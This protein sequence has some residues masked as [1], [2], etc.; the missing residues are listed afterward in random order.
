MIR[1][2]VLFGWSDDATDAQKKRAADE[3]MRLP[4]LVPS[5]RAFG[6][7]PDVG[8]NQG[9]F[10]FA[11]TADFDDVAGYVAYRDNPEHRAMVE[12]HILPIAARRATVQFEF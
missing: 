1:H 5:V 8:V 12:E 2:T 6:C 10:D 4:S 7:G 3:I 9:N 11:A